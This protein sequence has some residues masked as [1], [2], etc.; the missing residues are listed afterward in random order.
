MKSGD[1]NEALKKNMSCVFSIFTCLMDTIEN[2]GAER[3]A[4][5]TRGRPRW[6]SVFGEQNKHQQQET[7]IIKTLS[8]PGT[9]THRARNT[10]GVTCGGTSETSKQESNNSFGVTSVRS[11]YL[12]T[13][14]TDSFFFSSFGFGLRLILSCSLYNKIYNFTHYVHTDS[15]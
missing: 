10:P 9:P 5:V 13:N 6:L 15:H 14:K 3:E 12:P 2:H 11:N 7:N 8:S 4:G 1:K